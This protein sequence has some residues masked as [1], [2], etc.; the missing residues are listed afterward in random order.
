MPRTQRRQE[1]QA[2]FS[3]VLPSNAQCDPRPQVRIEQLGE[4]CIVWL[5]AKD[6]NETRTITCIR[7]SCCS[8]GELTKEGYSHPVLVLKIKQDGTCSFAQA[9]IFDRLQN[10]SS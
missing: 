3:D 10:V 2:T 1:W 9:S 7:D 6:E 4:G 5:P 8:N